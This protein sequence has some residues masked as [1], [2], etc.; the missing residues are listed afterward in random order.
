[1]ILFIVSTFY[2]LTSLFGSKNFSI[3][4]LFLIWVRDGHG[5]VADFMDE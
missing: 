5:L 4:P 1:M 2:G 3:Q